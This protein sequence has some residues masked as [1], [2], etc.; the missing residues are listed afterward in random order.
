MSQPTMTAE[1][2]LKKVKINIMR[3]KEFALMSGLMMAGTTKII[4]RDVLAGT[5]GYNEF[6]GRKFVETFSEKEVGYAVVHEAGHKM[7]RH[8]TIW[9]KLFK[10]DRELAN[11]ACDYVLN[12]FL[13]DMD[14]NEKI[15][16]RL[17]DPATGKIMILFDERFRGMNVKQ[18]FD[19]LKKE[20]KAGGGGGDGGGGSGQP[21]DEHDW[22]G[23]ADVTPEEAKEIEQEID[24]AVRQGKMLHEKLNGKGTSGVDRAVEELVTPKI[25]WRAELREFFTSVCNRKEDATYRKLHRRYVGLDM[26]M[27][28]RIS[29]A[30][31]RGAIGIDMSGSISREL[32]TFFTEAV[33]LLET[34]VPEAIDLLYW[35]GAVCQHETY[36]PDNYQNMLT[37]TSPKGGGGTSPSCV[38]RFIKDKDLKPEFVVMFTDGYVGSDWGEQWG[39]KWPCPVLWLIVNEHEGSITAPNGKTIFIREFD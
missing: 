4:D 18:V 14:R 16:S 17:R 33:S 34:V 28:I 20:Q 15:I 21:L 3:Q 13:Y 6:Y 1:R 38:T 25:D 37:S 8:L 30:A 31:G 24:R 32:P 35:D 39:D 22:E 19:I 29:E 10:E 2:K 36:T 11:H 23:A 5:D 7:F 26:Y 27:P 12:L 9:Q